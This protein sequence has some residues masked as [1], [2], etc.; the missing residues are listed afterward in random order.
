MKHFLNR[1]LKSFFC[2]FALAAV[3][4]CLLGCDSQPTK[5]AMTPPVETAKPAA[6][7]SSAP[8][9]GGNVMDTSVQAAPAGVKTGL[10]GGKK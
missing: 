9:K 8:P 5:E 3:S 1:K 6:D 2:A 10:D 7:A 4:Y